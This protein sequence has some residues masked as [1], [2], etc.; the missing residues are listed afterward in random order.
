ML[1]TAA[2]VINSASDSGQLVPML[3][4]AKELTGER[5]HLTLA[6][7]GYHTATNL[8]A[9]EHRGQ[10]LVMAE[11]YQREVKDPCFKDQFIYDT[12]TDSYVCPHGQRLPFRSLCK[13][14]LTGL[15]SIR[16]Y[17]ASRTSL[18]HLFG[19]WSL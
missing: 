1:I 7:G 9:G 17:R 3:E 4:Q 5:V 16:L 11:R 12:D 6:D 13:S 15:Q 14:P 8:E 18:P 19:F 10:V 2:D